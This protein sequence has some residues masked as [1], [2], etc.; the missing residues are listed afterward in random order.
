MQFNKT[1]PDDVIIY[2]LDEYIYTAHK[3]SVIPNIILIY[4]RSLF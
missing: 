1:A 3:L 2:K 4:S